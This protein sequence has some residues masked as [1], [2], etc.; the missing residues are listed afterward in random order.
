MSKK[1]PLFAFLLA[2][3]LFAVSTV[4]QAEV[5]LPSQTV[6]PDCEEGEVFDQG[7]WS[8]VPEESVDE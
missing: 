5:L 6:V 4:A 8:C 2:V 7:S 3:P 1:V